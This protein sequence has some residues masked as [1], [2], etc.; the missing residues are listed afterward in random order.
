MSKH[1]ITGYITAAP[2]MYSKDKGKLSVSFST[3][4]PSH[5]YEP[6]RVVV[7]E[8]TF[9]VEVSDKFDP[10]PGMVGNLEEAKREARAAYAKRVAQI[11]DQISR[12][13]AIEN[14]TESKS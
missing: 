4:K 2:I 14:S 8:H 7:R 11:D 13:L 5:E 6:E 10:R 1:T 12:L 3:Y 9:E